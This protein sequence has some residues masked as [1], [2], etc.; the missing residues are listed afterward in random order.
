MNGSLSIKTWVAVGVPILVAI[1][2][3]VVSFAVTYGG[4]KTNLEN[5]NSIIVDLKAEIVENRHKDEQRDV[6]LN[7]IGAD[8]KLLLYQ[9]KELNKNR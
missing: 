4:D 8:V 2:S 6:K 5:I 3:V 1:V 9:V 7:I